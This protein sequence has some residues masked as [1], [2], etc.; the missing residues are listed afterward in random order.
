M[1]ISWV[2]TS[3]TL[4]PILIILFFSIPFTRK[5]KKIRVVKSYKPIYRNLLSILILST[6]WILLAWLIG[7]YTNYF[8]A[9]I[10]GTIVVLLFSL[11]SV[12]E[13]ESN[14][15]DYFKNNE[16]CLDE[17]KVDEMYKKANFQE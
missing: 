13:N 2:I 11:G 14:V 16:D 17:K 10:F 5:L 3:F 4:V 7:R 12:G 1:G 15:Q 6:I 9:Y 8:F